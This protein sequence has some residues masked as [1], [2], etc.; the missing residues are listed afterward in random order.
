MLPEKK[1]RESDQGQQILV[2][3]DLETL[4]CNHDFLTELSMMG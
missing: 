4:R 3:H 2:A 1:G